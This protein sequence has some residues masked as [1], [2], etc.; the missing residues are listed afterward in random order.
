MLGRGSVALAL[1][2]AIAALAPGCG[3]DATGVEA[4]RTIETVRCQEAAGCGIK[5]DTPVHV[6]DDV[7]ACIRFYHDAC[8]HGLESGDPG[9]AKVTACKNEIADTSRA[10]HC[11]IVATP[12]IAD[13]CQWLAPPPPADQDASPSDAPAEGTATDAGGP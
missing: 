13:A 1:V 12:E 2:A 5:L 8:L 10:D 4:C 6:G 9:P 3:T 11:D 7:Q